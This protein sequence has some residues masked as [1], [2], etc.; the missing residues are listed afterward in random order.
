MHSPTNLPYDSHKPL[1]S[2]RLLPFITGII[3]L[4]MLVHAV[5]AVPTTAVHVVK[6]AADGTTVLNETSIEYRWMEANLPVQGDGNTHY[7]HQGPVFADEKEAQWDVSET[8]NFKDMGAV[9]GTAVRDLCDLVGGMSPDDEVMV[10]AGDGY[11]VEFPYQNIYSPDPRQGPVAICWFNGEESATG[12]RQGTGSP[13]GYH[14][15]MRLV[16]LAD[17]STNRVGQQVFGNQDMRAVMPAEMIHLFDNLYPSTSGYSVMWVDEIRIYPKGYR[18]GKDAL[19]KSYESK[20]D[21]TYPAPLA[22]SSGLAIKLSFLG[23]TLPYGAPLTATEADPVV[24]NWQ[25]PLKGTRENVLT[26]EK[27]RTFPVV[28][29]HGYMTS[30]T[31]V[32]FG[33]YLST[34]VDLRDLIADAGGMDPDDRVWIFGRDGYLWVFEADQLDG[35]GFVTFG[36]D[37]KEIPSPPLRLILMYEQDNKPVSYNDGGPFRIVVVSDSPNVITEGSSWV[38]WVDKIEIKKK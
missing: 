10:K 32:L 37:L 26:L 22:P 16:I 13:P 23:C 29:G 17:N 18:Q 11:H 31:G 25:I 7:Y 8:T 1:H 28:T 20:M 36:A 15:G 33:P 30:T 14:T 35:R 38:K 5:S 12:E 21:E 27:L 34:G 6:Y 2:V 3:L 9:K 4:F 24:K 19:P